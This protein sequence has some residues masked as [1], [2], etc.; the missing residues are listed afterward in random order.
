MS[1]RCPKEEMM[2]KVKRRRMIET[3]KKQKTWADWKAYIQSLLISS[4]KAV[5]SAL[6]ALWKMQ[7]EDE[8]ILR[9]STHENGVGFG[10]VDA[11]YLT[12][13][14]KRLECGGKLED[15]EVIL[16]RSKILKYWKQLAKNSKANLAKLIAEE[17]EE[18][19]SSFKEKNGASEGQ[20][21]IP[22]M[23]QYVMGGVHEEEK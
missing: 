3:M 9:M 19:M 5:V 18:N 12:P 17:E 6:M 8:R 10:K 23:E 4:D 21:I 22:G 11:Y 7:E 20:M 13:Y 1:S 16:V 2:D 14:C 15:W